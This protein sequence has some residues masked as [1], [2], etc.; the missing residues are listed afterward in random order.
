MASRLEAASG[1]IAWFHRQYI[2]P[3]SHGRT[4]HSSGSGVL[5][6]CQFV[7][8]TDLVPE[9]LHEATAIVGEHMESRLPAH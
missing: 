6:E 5:E 3:I 8:I 7:T 2:P 4:P 1:R 9:E